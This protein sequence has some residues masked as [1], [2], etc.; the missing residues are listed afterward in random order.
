MKC[1]TKRNEWEASRVLQQARRCNTQQATRQTALCIGVAALHLPLALLGPIFRVWDRDWG[2]G[3]SGCRRR[4]DGDINCS[5]H[6]RR[7][8]HQIFRYTHTHK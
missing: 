5:L 4:I 1:V 2:K 7:N 6:L 8:Q 3:W